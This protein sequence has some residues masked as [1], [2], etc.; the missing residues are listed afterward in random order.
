M[1]DRFGDVPQAAINLVKVSHA[2]FL[3]GELSIVRI[4]PEAKETVPAQKLTVK[5]NAA[6]KL[7]FDFAEKNPLSGY[8]LFNLTEKFGRK[9]FVHGG[10]QPFIR[11]ST[12]RTHMLSDSIELLETLYEDKKT[13][14][15]QK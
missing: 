11:L 2:R 4:H 6:V 12:D 9:V 1:L 15:V 8:A 7:V 3:A 5:D 13:A 10:T 14:G